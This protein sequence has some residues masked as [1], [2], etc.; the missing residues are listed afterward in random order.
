MSHEPTPDEVLALAREQLV[1]AGITGPHRSHT[2]SNV[3]SKINDIIDGTTDDTFG[4]TGLDK[5][6]SHEV[7]GFVSQFTAC[8][9]DVE[10]LDG[11][12]AID[13]D[14]TIAGILAA[15]R[16][17]GE[18]G[19][20]GALLTIGTG[21]P[22]GMLEHHIRIADVYRDLGGKILRPR[23]DETLRLG[24]SHREVRYTGGVACV[25]DWGAL[26]HTHSASAMEALLEADPW[27]D[28]VVGDHGF[29]G[30]AIERA[31]PT[32]AIMDINDPALAVA[33]AEGRDVTIVPLD[34][35]RLPR[36]YKPAWRL[37]SMAMRG[38][39]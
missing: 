16:R 38:E 39:L 6:S 13:P 11:Y 36:L 17:L 20:A 22:T 15:G 8:W 29:A 32:I 9:S 37:F 34:D 10:D 3:L 31:I 28:V 7:L 26:L 21:H 4:L 30:A 1:A 35:N 27:P 18:F 12:D 5:Y 23:E 19:R 25:A 14:L 2:K 24:R 33:A